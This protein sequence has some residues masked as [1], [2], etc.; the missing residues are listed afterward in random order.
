MLYTFK[1]LFDQFGVQF[2]NAPPRN[3]AVDKP[4]EEQATGTANTVVRN[5]AKSSSPFNLWDPS[6]PKGLNA[7]E[8]KRTKL[9]LLRVSLGLSCS[10]DDDD[11]EEDKEETNLRNEGTSPGKMSKE[12]C[13]C[14]SEWVAFCKEFEQL[15]K[16]QATTG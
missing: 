15:D 14:D 5:N 13:D 8:K 3:G 1:T 10:D 9:I 7:T 12:N 16:Q 2:N 4:I 11:E 6:G